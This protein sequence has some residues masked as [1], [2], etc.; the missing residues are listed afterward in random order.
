[1]KC[2]TVGGG[3]QKTLSK[4]KKSKIE[5]KHASSTANFN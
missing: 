4:P 2:F 5:Q 1:M 3:A